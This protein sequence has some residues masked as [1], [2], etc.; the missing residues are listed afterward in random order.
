MT[1]QSGIIFYKTLEF[2]YNV[3]YPAAYEA[4]VTVAAT[5]QNDKRAR[6]S[7]TGPAVEISAPGVDIISTYPGVYA[8]PDTF[9][10]GTEVFSK[11]TVTVTDQDGAAV[12]YISSGA[13]VNEAHFW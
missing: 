11:L 8:S 12:N 4:G 1:F 6:F 10:A 7:S 5:D 3:S 13:K 2:V 9:F